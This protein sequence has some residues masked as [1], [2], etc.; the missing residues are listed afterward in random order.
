MHAIAAVAVPSLFGW[1]LG[2][3][4][5]WLFVFLTLDRRKEYAFNIALL[6]VFACG[7]PSNL[8]TSL[9]QLAACLARSIQFRGGLA[10]L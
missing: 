2:G 7:G 3:N 8:H 10:R 9:L 4:G 1:T 5:T 6:A